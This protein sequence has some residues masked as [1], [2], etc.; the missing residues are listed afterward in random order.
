MSAYLI[1]HPLFINHDAD[2]FTDASISPAEYTA[3]VQQRQARVS[4]GPLEEVQRQQHE[5]TEPA[6]SSEGQQQ[7]SAASAASPAKR[8]TR[9]P[10][11]TAVKFSAVRALEDE[12]EAQVELAQVYQ[13]YCDLKAKHDML[14]FHDL[15]TK[16]TELL[17]TRSDVAKRVALRYRFIMV[18]EFQV[19]CCC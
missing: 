1:L 2:V 14:D 12:L 4:A 13:L 11:A 18:D 16:S 19:S 17:R 5:A 7:V 8:G 9:A 10:R 3:H 15:I 6:T